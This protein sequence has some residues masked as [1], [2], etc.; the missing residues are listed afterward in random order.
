MMRS[1]P[2]PKLK[3]DI[4]TKSIG[5]PDGRRQPNRATLRRPALRRPPFIPNFE[6]FSLSSRI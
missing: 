4:L 1:H 3:I 5:L 6:K 2:P